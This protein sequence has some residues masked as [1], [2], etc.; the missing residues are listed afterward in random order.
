MECFLTKIFEHT[1]HKNYNKIANNKI[2]MKISINL[3]RFATH[4]PHNKFKPKICFYKILNV[5][6][7]AT[8][9]EI[10][11]S[12]LDLARKYHPDTKHGDKVQEEK[13][14]QIQ[15]AYVVLSNEIQRRLYNEENGI[16]NLWKH[17]NIDDSFGENE[18]T[19]KKF[20]S[21][22]ISHEQLNERIKIDEEFAKYFETKYFKNKEYFHKPPVEDDPYQMTKKLLKAKQELRK[23]TKENYTLHNPYT[24]KSYYEEKTPSE[25]SQKN[26]FLNVVFELKFPLLFCFTIFTGYIIIKELYEGNKEKRTLERASFVE[27]GSGYHTKLMPLNIS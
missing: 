27:K 19:Y 3:K 1:K 26:N 17:R 14:K 10:K 21:E 5:S 13:F 25:N 2:L 8:Q 18:N 4:S 15:E 16:E 22:K 24:S 20:S 23:K 12:Y 7:Q 6:T 11:K 9:E